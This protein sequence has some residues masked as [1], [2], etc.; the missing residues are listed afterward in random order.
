MNVSF[1]AALLALLVL[2]MPAQSTPFAPTGA[3][4]SAGT[5]PPASSTTTVSPGEE[6]SAHGHTVTNGQQPNGS[7][8]QYA[9]STAKAKIRRTDGCTHTTCGGGFRGKVSGLSA[10]GTVTTGTNSNPVHVEGNGGHVNIGSGS[11]V[12]M[13]NA[14]GGTNMTFTL[15]GGSQGSIPPGNTVTI[16]G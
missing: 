6:K 15:P 3:T 1:G 2:T 5:T 10:G 4:P 11:T 7:G 8:S 9:G 12:T 14:S 16:T 13:T